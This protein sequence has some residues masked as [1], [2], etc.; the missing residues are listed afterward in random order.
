MNRS[1]AVKTVLQAIEMRS[2]KT[3]ARYLDGIREMADASDSDRGQVSCSNL[4]HA[5]AGALDDQTTLLTVD[6]GRAKNLAI[7]T[8]YNDMLSAHQPYENYPQQIKKKARSLGSMA[9]V[10][11]GVPAMCDGVTQGRPGMEL[12]LLSRDVIAMSTAVALSHNVYDA[13]VALGICD[14]IVPGLLMGALSFGHLPTVFIP[15][16]P[17]Q[18]GI[19]NDQKSQVRKAYAKG[20]VG[21]DELLAS[22]AAAYHSP[23]TCTFYGT[24][25][26]NQMLLEMMG[27]QLPGSSFINPGDDIRQLLTDAA[28]EAALAATRGSNHYL[29]LGVVIDA[30]AIVNAIVGLHATGGSTNHTMHLIAIAQ[31]AGLSVTWEDFAALSKVTPLIARVYPNGSADVNHFHAAGGMG[32][33]MREL[34][35]ANLLLGDALSMTGATIAESIL[36]PTVSG[37]ELQWAQAQH[38]SLDESILKTVD[39]PF[40]ETGGLVHLTGNIGE[41]VIKTSAVDTERQVIEAPCMVF[42][43][44]DEVKVAFQAGH[45]NQDV[46]VV[47]RGQGPK[48]NGMP[49]LHGLTP[50]LSILQD[51]GHQVALVTDGRMSGASGKVPA[52][53]HVSP[54]AKDGGPIS[55]IENGD[56]IRLDATTGE[57]TILV[58]DAILSARQS[59]VV[60]EP[61]HPAPWG[62]SLFSTLRHQAGPATLGGGLQLLPE[63]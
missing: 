62:R 3:R 61:T 37:G 59:A 40:Q 53:I 17:M 15:A 43:C 19:S 6:A 10:A 38:R 32:Y 60:S 58:D 13:T 12:S 9:Q 46:V 16:G 8:A 24:A 1:D 31:A 14:K 26:S 41:A 42:D 4:A 63:A 18:T 21:R 23:G 30:R 29:P 47:V 11:G 56:V 36:E 25:N 33:V 2:Q 52:A 55:R 45:L 51:Q 48:A 5:A 20:E 27:V 50:S 7:V 49:E 39:Q 54:E 34:F 57:L 22:E 44:E 35:D 28:V